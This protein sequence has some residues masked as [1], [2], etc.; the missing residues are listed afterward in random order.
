VQAI[1]SI[2]FIDSVTPRGS[3]G[4]I[5]RRR[6][7]RVGGSKGASGALLRAARQDAG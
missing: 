6:R 5:D 3:I 2:R 4:A 7:R 1:T